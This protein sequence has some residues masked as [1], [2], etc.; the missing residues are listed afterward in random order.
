MP[1]QSSPRRIR[2]VGVSGSGKTRLAAA[3]ADHL[4]VAHLEL[5]AIFWDRDWTFRDLAQARALVADFVADHPAGWVADGNWSTRLAGLLDPPEGCDLVVWLDHPRWLVMSRVVRRTLWRGLS[6]RA[7][8]HGNRERVGNWLS[9]D[10]EQNI[11]L[12]AWQQ[13]GVM[14][15]RMQPRVGQPG[16]LR[17]RGQRAVRRWLRSLE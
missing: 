14:R 1:D 3:A 10:P 8:W 15:E 5:D 11:M 7:L 9:R 12:W 2:V 13:H 6:R 16:Y 17:L 4:G